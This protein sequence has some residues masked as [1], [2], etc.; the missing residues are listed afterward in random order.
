M[1]RSTSAAGVA[2]PFASCVRQSFSSVL[3]GTRPAKSLNC[4]IVN[5]STVGNG[6]SA[7]FEATE[8]GPVP[9]W[10]VAATLNR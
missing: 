10:F 5:R 3:V 1:A 2:V 4:W 8:S 7:R 6:G 9:T